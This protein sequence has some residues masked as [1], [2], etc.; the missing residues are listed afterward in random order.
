[1][2]L[3]RIALRNYR[4]FEEV[5]LEVPAGLVGIYGPNGAGKSCLVESIRF[6]LWGKSRTAN[7]DV[8]T[9][10]VGGDCVAE[11][12]FEH[13][14]HLY[15]VRRTIS[16]I[17][18]TVRA[19]ARANGAQVAEG[20]RDVG[21]YLHAILGM[22]D[23]AFRASVFAE[24]K[25]VAAFSNQ[26]PSK[27][28]ELVLRLLGI[29]PL[30]TARDDARRDAREASAAHDRLRELLADLVELEAA[31]AEAL[32]LQIVADEAAEA[33]SGL[34]ASARAR[35]DEVETRL[36][37]L[38]DLR[39][40]HDELVAEGKAVRAEHDAATEA[41]ARLEAE[42]VALGQAAAAMAALRPAAEGLETAEARLRQLE[43][44]ALAEQALAT[45][46]L[47]AE[48]PVPDEEATEAAR[49]EAAAKAAAVAGLQGAHGAAVAE[50]DRARAA[51]S[52]S[53]ELSGG[54]S[55]PLCGQEL[56][57]AF[58]EVQSH[59]DDELREAS[60]RVTTL[61]AQVR[62]A[63]KA[64]AAAT[65][66][67]RKRVTELDAA[68]TAAR[69]YQQVHERRSVAERA[70]AEALEALGTPPEPGEATALRAE[71]TGRREAAEECRRLEVR[72]ERLGV[73]EAQ[74][75]EATARVLDA[76]GRRETLLEKVRS[77][78]FSPDDLDAA[79]A[80]RTVARA[81]VDAAAAAGASARLAAATAV[82]DVEAS[83]ARLEAAR[84]QHRRIADLAD[85]ARHVGR[86]ADLLNAFRTNVVA[87]VG[88]RLALQAAELF[89][90]LTDHEYDQLEVD[91]ETYEIQIRDAGRLH[92][93]DRFSGS[94]TDLA[95]LALR[96]AISEHVRF[97]SGGAVGLLVLDEVF[98][99]LD[100]DRKE[101]ML[102]AL[103]RLRSRFRQ[104]LVVTHADDVKEQLPSA[105]EVV[106]LPGRRAT[107]RVVSGV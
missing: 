16:G 81:A 76:A 104:I 23:A 7:E 33:A 17:N 15:L 105:V 2:R 79:R 53:A 88:P 22:D 32:R 80:E 41:A 72:L 77:L 31:L 24:Q 12:E 90:E 13:E 43:V 65:A 3:T 89:A 48:A 6:A 34:E 92:G 40:T 74:L 4:V 35:A 69:A 11:I 106:K 46:V 49:E 84:E 54:G 25:Q 50:L 73:V 39:R 47:P 70:L 30:D 87:T 10:G 95:N 97:Q 99:P 85:R 20:A 14:G 93:M 8:R 62:R 57:E 19:E 94:E 45:L 102:L 83:G 61:E 67:A 21:R 75:A 55:C 98:G 63:A 58:H 96:V 26:T 27:R 107:A 29:T 103:E 51:A 38:D 37:R 1:M 36:E 78:C 101:R 91:P 9:T 5:E 56:G 64:A 60:E 82:K 59:R 100:G 71:V 68:R 52:R 42:R 28:R 44:V 18:S 86:L 66:A